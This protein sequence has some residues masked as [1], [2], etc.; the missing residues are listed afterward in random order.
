[1]VTTYICTAGKEEQADTDQKDV[2]DESN[3]SLDTILCPESRTVISVSHAEIC[4]S[5][6]NEAEE[7]VEERAHQREQITEEWNDLGNDEG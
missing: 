6:E 7:A 2:K 5:P 4:H 1:M 3:P